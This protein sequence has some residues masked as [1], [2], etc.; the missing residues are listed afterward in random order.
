M[1]SSVTLLLLLSKTGLCG[2]PKFHHACN[3]FLFSLS[4]MAVN[5]SHVAAVDYEEPNGGGGGGINE[6]HIRF[7]TQG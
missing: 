1:H 2:T 3:T 4:R 7:I 6:D 5:E